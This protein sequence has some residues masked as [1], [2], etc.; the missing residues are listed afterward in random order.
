MSVILNCDLLPLLLIAG[1][2]RMVSM[3]RF[4]NI[5]L[6]AVMSGVKVAL[7]SLSNT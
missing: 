3:R 1:A 2:E 5:S 6:H 4:E 7:Q